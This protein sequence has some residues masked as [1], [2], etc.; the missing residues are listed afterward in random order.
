MGKSLKDK[1][2]ME[3][4][5]LLPRLQ[6]IS[7]TIATAEEEWGVHYDRQE[8]E[9]QYLRNMFYRAGDLMNDAARLLEQTFDEVRDQGFLQKQSNGRYALNGTELFSN[10]PIEFLH[11]NDGVRSWVAT[12]IEHFDGDYRLVGYRDIP[13]EG[14]HIR[15]KRVR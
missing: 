14:L 12:R 15:I 9:E 5:E 4:E 3:L 1:I 2:A 10:S 13:L 6:R 7:T 11:V 8:P